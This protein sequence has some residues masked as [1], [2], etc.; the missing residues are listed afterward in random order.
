M[1]ADLHLLLIAVFCATDDLLPKRAAADERFLAR[2][3]ESS[4]GICSRCCPSGPAT[5]APA[6]TERNRVRRRLFWAGLARNGRA[7]RR[8]SPALAV[9]SSPFVRGRMRTREGRG[10][11][12]DAVA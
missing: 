11:R 5:T 9:L 2:S 8:R 10:T 12:L 7:M 3:T 1:L 4:S 6:V